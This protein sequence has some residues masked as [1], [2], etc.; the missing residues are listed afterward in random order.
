ME[1]YSD[2]I[3]VSEF[4]KYSAYESSAYLPES[5]ELSYDFR[6]SS[7]QSSFT[8]SISLP[9]EVSAQLTKARSDS[10]LL[11]MQTERESEFKRT[12]G[13]QSSRNI[14]SPIKTKAFNNDLCQLYF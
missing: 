1:Q 6:D 4:N 2:E 12:L 8:T 10:T 3:H 9:V 13:V 11:M 7:P 5:G 14:A